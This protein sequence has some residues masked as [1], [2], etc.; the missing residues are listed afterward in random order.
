MRAFT[1][2][3][4]SNGA[5]APRSGAPADGYTLFQVT[6]QHSVNVILYR[7]LSYDLMR[8]FASVTQI[9]SSPAIVVVHP[10]LPAKSITEL[11]KLA[12]AKP[13]AIKFGS[14]GFGSPTFVA[15]ELFKALAGVS[16]MHVPYRGGGEALIAVLTGEAPLYFA[17]LTALPHIRQ[18]RLRPLA[19]TA[20]K[21][22]PLLPEYPTVAESGYP[23]YEFGFWHGLMVPAKTPK[24][25]IAAIRVAVVAVLNRPDTSE[26]IRDLGYTIV[27]DQ[28][29]EFAQFIRSDIEKWRKIIHEKNITED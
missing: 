5:P 4:P 14:A 2:T 20:A 29:E 13:G 28:P 19:L 9:G 6:F 22:L 26:R 25:T 11:V 12:K 23:G 24:E 8:D 27:G 21:R 16:L 1:V 3:S 7:N 18:G 10:S 17:P 15:A